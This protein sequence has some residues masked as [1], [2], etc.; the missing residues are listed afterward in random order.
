MFLVA[1]KKTNIDSAL[2]ITPE[3]Y[4]VYQIIVSS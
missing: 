4:R 1:N 3:P 2:F